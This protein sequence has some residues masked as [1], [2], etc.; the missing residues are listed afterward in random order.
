[1][2][3]PR[4]VSKLRSL[5][6]AFI[7]VLAIAVELLVWGGDRG[8]RGGGSL[9]LWVVPALT[10]L[11]FAVLPRRRQRPVAVFWVQWSYALAG[12]VLPG[13]EPFAGLLVA[14]HAVACRM[15]SRLAAVALAACIL[16]FAINSYNSASAAKAASFAASF[17]SAAAL[18]AVL[19][20]AVWGL[21]RLSFAAERRADLMQ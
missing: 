13:Y 2:S 20:L 21:G 1:M 7:V 4:I 8:L 5:G 9:P 10:V 18:W 16:P 17:A 6:N 3:Q 19:S 11:V 12:L 14:L 15:R